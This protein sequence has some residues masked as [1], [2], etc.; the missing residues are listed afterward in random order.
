ME[1]KN[2]G[3]I[4]SWWNENGRLS[5]NEYEEKGGMAVFKKLLKGEILPADV[6]CELEDSELQGR[7][8]A[9]FPIGKKWRLAKEY[10]EKAKPHKYPADSHAYFICNADES[11]PG[12]YK[13]RTII[14]KSPFLFLEGMLV[15]AF[16][17][18]AQ[19]GFIYINGSYQETAEIIKRSLKALEDANWLGENIQGSSFSFSITVFEGAGSYVCG[20]ETALINSIEGKRGEPRSKPPFPVEKGLFG[21]PTVINNVETLSNIPYI[22]R[23]GASKFKIRSLSGENAGT[24]IFI[25]NG[26]VKNPGVYEAPLGTTI[27]ELLNDYAGGAKMN[28]EIKYVQV[29]GS[30]GSIYN[31]NDFKRPIGYSKNEIPVGSGA[32]LFIDSSIDIK[33]LILAWSAFFRRESCGK[34]IPCREG[35]YHLHLFAEKIQKKKLSALDKEKLEDIIFTLKR[36]SLCPL[37]CFSV[38]SWESVIKEFPQEIFG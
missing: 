24:K 5:L 29:G 7:G 6:I 26:A 16:V 2:K 12:T 22:L 3:I 35:T 25:L 20:E 13:D 37:G 31:L 38:S 15:G 8:G 17:I 10:A 28:K 27:E 11:E 32:L 33:R 23:E 14:E 30:S 9:G 18:G 36:A 4:S 19:R 34:C 1:N 21:R